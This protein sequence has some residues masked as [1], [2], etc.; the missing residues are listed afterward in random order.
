MIT[1]RWRPNPKPQWV[2]C[3]PSNKNPELVP[4]YAR[5]LALALDLPFIPIV[6]KIRENEEQKIQQNLYHQCQ[7]LDGVFNIKSGMPTGAVLLV[8]DVV[9]SALT[10]T[11]ISALLKKAGSGAVFPFALTTSSI[12]S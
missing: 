5:R 2:T 4:N 8:D 7:N 3:V 12:G 10:L 6:E 9:D 11:I 1:Q